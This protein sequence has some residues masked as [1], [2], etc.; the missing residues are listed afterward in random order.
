MAGRREGSTGDG[1]VRGVAGVVV[2]LASFAALALF[3]G[4]AFPRGPELP[5]VDGVVVEFGH[6]HSPCGRAVDAT[7]V[8]FRVLRV[9]AG[10]P[11]PSVFDGLAVC[12][13]TP[14]VD[15]RGSA[16]P[17]DYPGLWW[18]DVWRVTL[19][20][21]VTG[22]MPPPFD[23]IALGDP[24]VAEPGRVLYVIEDLRGRRASRNQH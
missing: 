23:A 18:G 12:V 13:P 8:R 20:P 15:R 11:P 3:P 21:R 5:V 10:E 17:T 7:V 22:S 19:G 6:G 9:H 14:T 1:R 4:R 16:R 2:A 24:F